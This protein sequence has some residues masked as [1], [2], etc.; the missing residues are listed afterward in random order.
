VNGV[1][2]AAG[3][4]GHV[5]DDGEPGPPRARRRRSD[6]RKSEV[7]IVA[8]TAR[9]LSTGAPV[10]MRTVADTAGVS[11]STLY[12]HFDNPA[13]LQ[14][15]V[16]RQVL[17]EVSAAIERSLSERRPPLAE[18]RSVVSALVEIGAELPLDAPIGPPPRAALAE[19]A[20]GLRPL[21]QRLAEAAGFGEPPTAA[22]LAAGIAHFAEACL[23]AGRG[24]T[25]E[26]RATVERLLGIITDPLDRGLLLLDANGTVVAVN[27]EGREALASP[28]VVEPRRRAVIR[29]GGLYEDG[30]SAAAEAHPLTAALTSGEAHEG[31]R[32]Q[33]TRDGELRWYFV[34]VR[35]LQRT[36]HGELYGFVAVF[37]D[38]TPEKRFQFAHLRPP[39][40]L[41]ATTPPL[42][43]VVR[44]LDEV[45]APLLPEQLIAEAARLTGA[46]VA[47]YVLDI[48]GSHLLRLAGRED[49]PPQLKA[50]L[51]LGPEL[52]VDG[53]PELA[54]QLADELPGVVMAPMWLRGRAVGVLLALRD[55]RSGLQEVA[56]L[57]AAAMELANGYTDVMDAARRRREM[58]PAAEIQQS[59]I[60][61]RI[62]RLGSGELAGSVLPSYDVGG[63]WFDYVENQDGA[64]IAIADAAGKG[65]QA[66]GL[67]SVG[68]AA[69]RAARRNDATLEQAMQT[70]HETMSDVGGPEFFL[71][72]IVARWHP[73]YSV[74][75]WINCGHPPPLLVRADGT[76]EELASRPDLPLGVFE[77][78]RSFHRH[79][80]R[81]HDGDRLILYS[82]GVSRRRTA[83][84]PFGTDGI[85]KAARGATPSAPATARAIQEAVV[86]ASE[87]ALPDD[88]A[89]VVFAVSAPRGRTSA[90]RV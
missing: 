87:D 80:R 78:T 86:S 77:R 12:R 89:V 18:L 70:M 46:P 20:D 81:L 33:Q 9:L 55:S 76:V 47:L 48:D 21:A 17:A 62:A 1:V 36:P 75:S 37:T 82:D 83:D 24:G 10:T 42:L 7:A 2:W 39:G 60:P 35:P 4:H 19:A 14:L 27:V 65:P 16:Q 43:D 61:P 54:A 45:P 57:G 59:L 49:F 66:A 64:W 34:D 67:G 13:E 23:R 25:L 3:K 52:A 71:T 38:L 90:P 53:L 63:D 58:N 74:F 5:S 51:A 72:A 44:A 22:W 28:N 40:E 6:A 50:P 15:A 41:G 84:G 29:R 79:Q 69:L 73:V 31:V 11:R 85:A 56:R 68:L 8:A 88:A 32:G 30:S 26:S